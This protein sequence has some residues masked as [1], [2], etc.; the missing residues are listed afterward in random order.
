[1]ESAYT[2]E[3]AISPTSGAVRWV[4]V[5]SRT[6]RL[7]SEATG[8]LASLRARGCSPNTERVYAGR[9]ALYL[10]YCHL[11]RLQW[12]APGFTGLSLLQQWLVETPLPARTGRLVPG[13]VRHRSR[14]TAN[15]VMTVV[16]E[17]LRF[18]ALH[19]WVASRT[20]DL[21]A[22]P[23]L[24]RFALPGYDAG[25][26]GQHRH[27]QA[28][29]FRFK[30][31]QAGYED[32][33]PA[34]I[35]HMIASVS[36]ARDRFLIALLACTG[37]RIGE[38][39]GLHR[40]DLHLLASSRIVGCGIEGPHVHV[41]RRTDNPNRALAKSRFPRSV[42]VIAELVA[43]YTDYQYERDRVPQA[44][45]E[46]MVFVNLFRTARGRPMT[47]ANTKEM[48]DRLARTV[49]HACRPHMLRHSAATRWLRDGVDRDVVQRLLGHV[50]PLSMETYRNVDDAEMRAAVEH[51]A[52]LREQS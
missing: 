46:P 10:N 28:A 6:Y 37:L 21:L 9:L 25:E 22:Q 42:P 48:F 27:V 4:V 34:Q 49:R 38:A 19:G 50:S 16:G 24:L 18:G 30:T 5:E 32:L 14:G 15:A 35:R 26:R 52:F 47:Y 51:V 20:T 23:K 36:R 39:L 1:M 31:A 11:R 29:A 33:S 12:N 8:Y 3:R 17:F 45:A 13:R 7:H 43:L 40:A 44:S 41:R 2:A